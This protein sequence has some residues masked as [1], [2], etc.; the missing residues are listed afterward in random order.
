MSRTLMMSFKSVAV[1]PVRMTTFLFSLPNFVWKS[2]QI[3]SMQYA[4]QFESDHWLSQ[5]IGH[6]IR[7]VVWIDR[8]LSYQIFEGFC[9]LECWAT[10]T[11]LITGVWGGVTLPSTRPGA[12][13]VMA[14]SPLSKRPKTPMELPEE[15]RG[16][17]LSPRPGM[18][19]RW[20]SGRVGAKVITLDPV[21][22]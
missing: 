14:K 1:S 2:W 9:I 22:L 11:G 5:V 13:G 10:G 3:C 16:G 19:E 15:D 18:R 4:P 17:D 12:A 21:Q 7:P 6:C 20:P 8:F